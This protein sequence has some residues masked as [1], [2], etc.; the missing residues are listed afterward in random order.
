M[1]SVL[2]MVEETGNTKVWI[3]V[4]CVVP[5]EGCELLSANKGAY[6]NFLTL[7]N[8]E[9]EYRAKIS[10]ALGSYCLE[11]LGLEDVRPLSESDGASQEI[12]TIAEELETS[13]ALSK[14]RESS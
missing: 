5:R 12:M 9:S 14:L 2:A 10:G 1:G 8:S 4:A 6:V 3:A 11:L 13:R 7:A